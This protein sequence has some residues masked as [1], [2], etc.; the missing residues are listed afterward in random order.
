MTVRCLINQ[1]I[2]YH[3]NLAELFVTQEQSFPFCSIAGNSEYCDC[4]AVHVFELVF[5]KLAMYSHKFGERGQGQSN[6]FLIKV[7]K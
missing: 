6:L 2:D 5:A 1:V 3:A 4:Y 7:D